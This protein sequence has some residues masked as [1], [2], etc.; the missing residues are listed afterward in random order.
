MKRKLI[1][2]YDVI[3]CTAFGAGFWPWGPG[4][5]GAV[6]GVILWWLASL[7]LPYKALIIATVLAIAVV[8]VV[9]IPSINRL[10]RKWGPD[11]SRVVIDEVVGVWVCLLLVPKPMPWAMPYF[12][13]WYWIIA[14]FV[15]FRLLDIFK[16]LPFIRRMEQLPRGLGVMMDDVVAGIVGALIMACAQLCILEFLVP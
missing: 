4:T 3:L 14:A 2:L 9:S 11:P 5:M 7:V 15:L 10:E 12:T 1:K 13:T 8:T 6:V 16:P